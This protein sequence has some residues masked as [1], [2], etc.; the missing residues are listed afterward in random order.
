MS[1]DRFAGQVALVTGGA[2]GIG[3]ATVHAFASEGA[4]V[5]IVDRDSGGAGAAAQEV[6]EAGGKA[7]AFVVDL[8]DASAIDRVVE[9]VLAAFGRIDVLVNS[10]GVSGAPHS[11]VDFT[12]EKYELVTAIN[13]RAPFLLVRAVG[14]HMIARGGGGKI[15]N[16]SSSAAFRGSY[17]PAIY[18]AT[19]SGVN[20]LTRAAAADLGG[21]DVNVNAVAPGLTDT[22]MNA[23]IGDA[24]E[25]RQGRIVR[26]AVE[27]AQAALGA[28][29]RGQRDPVPLPAGEPSD[30]GSG[31]PHQ[32]WTHPLTLVVRLRRVSRLA[33]S[34]TRPVRAPQ[35]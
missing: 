23:G 2:S 11:A 3:R 20:G 4:Q 26:S 24:D 21:H 29:R 33:A 32:R 25:L 22:P 13:L 18:A 34:T 5:A 1:G 17:S 27:P 8:A 19:K 16:L 14:R 28:G 7:K 35:R 12:D 9:E 6:V 31:H 15:V 30:H 10:A